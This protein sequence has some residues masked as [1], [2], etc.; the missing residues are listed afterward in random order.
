MK[1]ILIPIIATAVFIGGCA[2]VQEVPQAMIDAENSCFTAVAEVKIA[3]A[4]RSSTVQIIEFKDERNYVMALAIE[5]LGKAA[6]PVEVSAFVPCTLTVQ[7]F[8]RESGQTA[9]SMNAIT[10]KAVG[11]LGV[12]GGIYV[13]GQA[14]EGILAGAG[15]TYVGSRVNSA[16]DNN[17]ALQYQTGA[18]SQ[19]TNAP[20]VVEEIPEEIPEELPAEEAPI[21]EELPIE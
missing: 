1:K 3:Q 8:L 18:G 5:Q 4:A 13:G 7:A 15:S 11:V 2:S 14:I 9:R 6:S 10:S 16:G 17:A 20:P 12:V 21:E 19:A